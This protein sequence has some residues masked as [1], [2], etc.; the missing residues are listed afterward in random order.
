MEGDAMD[1][2][3]LKSLEGEAEAKV[4][5]FLLSSFHSEGHS[6]LLRLLQQGVHF[7]GAFRSVSFCHRQ[8]LGIAAG[9]AGAAVA[10]GEAGYPKEAAR[11][12]PQN[13]GD[14][15]DLLFKEAA[16]QTRHGVLILQLTI[17]YLRSP[18]SARDFGF[19]RRPELV[20]V[21]VLSD[22]GP[23]I[24]SWRE[25]MK[26]PGLFRR[27]FGQ[28]QDEGALEEV[29]EILETRAAELQERNESEH[30]WC[31]L[32]VYEVICALLH[33]SSRYSTRDIAAAENLSKVFRLTG[34]EERIKELDQRLLEAWK[35]LCLAEDSE[36]EEVHFTVEAMPQPKLQAEPTSDRADAQQ[37]EDTV[38]FYNLAGSFAEMS[39]AKLREAFTC[40]EGV[41]MH[42]HEQRGVPFF[43]V[44]VFRMGSEE[45]IP[46]AESYTQMGEPEELFIVFGTLSQEPSSKLFEVT[47]AEREDELLVE[48]ELESVDANVRDKRGET[49]ACKASRNG[50][51]RVLRRLQLARADFTMADNHGASPLF[52]ACQEGKASCARFLLDRCGHEKLCVS[53]DD[54]EEQV[55]V[56]FV[57]RPLNSEA[58]PLYVASQNGHHGNVQILIEHRCDVNKATRDKATPLFIASQMGFDAIVDELIQAK[59]EVDTPNNTGAT[60]L[61]IASQNERLEIAKKLID[62]RA[63][64]NS[65]TTGGATP[66]YIAAQKDNKDVAEL[67]FERGAEV[68][69]QAQDGATPMLIAAQNGN[70][71][72]VKFLLSL[73]VAKKDLCMHSGAS[74]VFV[75]AQNNHLEVVKA[76]V[77]HGSNVTLCLRSGVSAVYIAAQNGN[78]EVVK[79]L[80]QEACA[81]HGTL[82]EDA[83]PLGDLEKRMRN[84]LDKPAVGE[85]RPLFI[86]CQ[87]GHRDVVQFLLEMKAEYSCTEDRSSPLLVAAQNGHLG[88]VEV[89]WETLKEEVGLNL[90]KRG[91]AT[92]LYIACQNGHFEVVEKLVDLKAE[93]NQSLE[94]QETPIFIACQGGFLPVVRLLVEHQA[95]VDQAK[96]DG[97]SPLYIACQ[98]GH[99][100]VVRYL[101]CESPRKP[102]R[103]QANSNQATP[104]FIASQKGH[105]AIVELLLSGPGPADVNKPLKSGAT[106]F[107]IASLKGHADVIHRLRSSGACINSTPKHGA[108]A[109]SAAVQ[110][111]HTEVLDILIKMRADVCKA[112]GEEM[113]PLHFAAREGKLEMA[114]LLIKAGADAAAKCK[115]RVP[116]ALA[117]EAAAKTV[118]ECFETRTIV[119]K[120]TWDTLLQVLGAD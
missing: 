5:D 3:F 94:S 63:N 54:A 40:L 15:G 51:L 13:R 85:A 14:L 82:L 25:L 96:Q 52:L 108:T 68:N 76:L 73:D 16:E 57:D 12:E 86:A 103:D 102:D 44:K 98:N 84:L 17:G 74:P 11:E 106:P 56:D 114:K 10:A 22:Q 80:L 23:E 117:E 93:V 64:V 58:T 100:E 113:T 26:S 8:S 109:V 104:L 88:V 37:R 99:V 38:H 21:L 105:T 19:L 79:Y 48:K 1:P 70:L 32:P 97:A 6:H 62:L 29:A 83:T 47:E 28:L 77:Q 111:D 75:S 78:L 110:N 7:G 39:K 101:L 120:E 112:N 81:E 71:S 119:P 95:D 41:R 67:L 24:V 20:H 34:Q 35:C 33:Q 59:A 60:P 65:E 27:A 118:P 46:R 31:M 116:R 50:H 36:Y 9:A 92:P 61:F 66:M 87:N 4:A 30:P 91:G 115:G 53:P 55:W 49:A 107:Y 42:F 72:T 45:E 18:D 69:T 2:Q 89:L 43:S 90:A